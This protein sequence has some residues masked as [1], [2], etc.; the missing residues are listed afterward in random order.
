LLKLC[1]ASS[2][3]VHA[4]KFTSE[5]NNSHCPK[6]F[7]FSEIYYCIRSIMNSPCTL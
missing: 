7:Q 5:W 4:M 2:R 1:Q 3:W 6:K